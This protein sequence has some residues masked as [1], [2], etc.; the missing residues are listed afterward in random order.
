MAL[1]RPPQKGLPRFRYRNT[2]E[3]L[4]DARVS[5]RRWWWEY[6]RLSKDYWL[7]SQTHGRTLDRR[8]Y[9]IWR[10]FG[11]VHSISFDDWWIDRGAHL[12]REQKEPPKVEVIRSDLSNLKPADET[13][14]VIEIPLVLRKAT[15]QRQIG[16]IL[17][18]A[19]FVRPHNILETSKSDFPINPVAYRLQVLQKM[20]QVWCEHRERILKPKYHGTVATGDEQRSD[21]FKL[22]K[23]M[24]ISPSNAL[25]SDDYDEQIKR[26]NRMRATVSRYIRRANQLIQN[27]EHGNFPV[28]RDISK[29]IPDRFTHKQREV[30]KELEQQWWNMDLRAKLADNVL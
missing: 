7:V 25:I 14:L 10:K 11:D 28:F 16:K 19:D 29:S 9:E 4:R 13:R 1:Q 17:A 21:L 26:N 27:V 6:L 8:L 20:H 22:G 15:I 23:E 3:E 24:G 30:H 2:E 18:Q 12:F 5:V